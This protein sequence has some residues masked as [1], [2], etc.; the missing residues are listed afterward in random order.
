VPIE[1][2]RRVFETNIFAAVRMLQC[3][4]RAMPE[5]GRGSIVNVASRLAV[6]GVD[7]MTV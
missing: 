4:A 5:H 6:I 2:V 3:A 7:T 1:D